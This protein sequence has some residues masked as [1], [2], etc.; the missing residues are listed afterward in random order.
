MYYNRT[1]TKEFADHLLPGNQLY[2][3]FEY[4]K[5]CPDLDFQIGKNATEEWIS[6]YRGL[7][8]LVSI[9]RTKNPDSVKLKTA[10]KYLDISPQLSGIRPI[11]EIS[12]DSIECVRAWLEKKKDD[13][14]YNNRKEGYYQNEL[15]RMFG[16][17]GNSEALYAVVDKEAVVG[18]KNTAEKEQLFLPLQ[19]KYKKLQ[20]GLSACDAARYGEN[21]DSKSIGKELDFLAIDKS[22]DLMLIE[23]KHGTNTSGIYLSPLQIGLYIETFSS[24]PKDVLS[25]SA[26]EMFKQKQALGLISPEWKMPVLSGRI[27][28]VLIISEP[29]AKSDAKQKFGEVLD[30]CKKKHGVNFLE[31]LLTFEYTSADGMRPWCTL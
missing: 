23:Y 24:L 30:F 29:N 11:S 18:Y 9:Q 22:G 25:Q 13:R 26:T 10:D 17:C 15:S 19:Q 8:R 4:V 2:W 1:L 27:V 14:Y 12:A 28:P 20:Q 31:G 6:V 5:A 3:L 7:T 16:I 21:L